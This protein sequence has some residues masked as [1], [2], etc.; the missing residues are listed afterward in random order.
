MQYID[1]EITKQ[2][3]PPQG[4]FKKP[5]KILVRSL[6]VLE[7]IWCFLDGFLSVV[8]AIIMNPIHRLRMLR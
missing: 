2:S 6:V 1:S 7:L 4:Q 3:K 8:V 5:V